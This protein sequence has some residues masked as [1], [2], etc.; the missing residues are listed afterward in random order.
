MSSTTVAP[1]SLAGGSTPSVTVDSAVAVILFAGSLM[2]LAHGGV[3]PLRPQPAPLDAT[4]IA[5]TAAATLPLVTARRF[6]LGIFAVTSAAAIAMT[7]LDYPVDL[8]IGPTVALYRLITARS[9][10][11]AWVVILTVFAAYVGTAAEVRTAVPVR[12]L[13]HTGLAWAAAWFAAERTKFRQDHIAS[14]SQRAQRAERDAERERLLALAEE[15]ARIA[16]DLHDSAGHTVSL[17]AVR[18]GAARLRHH[19]DPGKSLATLT[20]IEHLARQTAADIDQI[21]GTLRD[22]STD[23]TPATPLGL[24]SL[25]TL[26]AHHEASGLSITVAN[27]GTSR[28]LSRV[29]DATVYRI[30][31]EALANAARHGTGIATVTIDFGDDALDV[32]VANPIAETAVSRPGGGHGLIGMRE[33]ATIL[34][35]TVNTDRESPGFRLQAHVPYRGNLS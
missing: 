13:F 34:G 20:D 9:P 14:L 22:R 16:R 12:E 33:R 15:R 11:S 29:A 10:R 5:L 18:A 19:D 7:A 25:E 17:I 32:T 23:E 35:G 1:R 30:L 28:T 8:L 21:V 3:I 26:I 4:G 2:L 27:T 24:S 31:Q 6:P